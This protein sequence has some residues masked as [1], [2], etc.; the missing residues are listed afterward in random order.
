MRPFRVSVPASSANLGPGFDTLGLA[1]N[2]WN[3]TEFTSGAPRFRLEVQGEGADRLP[4]SQ[5]NLIYT[6]LIHT[7]R[8]ARQ[9]PPAGLHIRCLNRI[10]LGAGLGS[11]AAACLTGI[12]AANQF[13][14]GV[15]DRAQVIALAA[16]LEGHADNAAP[17]ALGGLTV[18]AHGASGLLARRVAAPDLAAVV[19]TPEFHLPTK[20]ARAALPDAYPRTDAIANIGR[21]ALVVEALRT[22]DRALLAEVIGDSL[23]QPYRLPLIPGAA[24]A[25]AAANGLGAPAALSGAGPSLIAFPADEPQNVGAAMQAAFAAAGLA[26]QVRLLHT[27]AEGARITNI[28]KVP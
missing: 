14:N 4:A 28:Q 17:A 22:N 13:L 27:S 19:V 18:V 15:F 10:P 21:T 5:K 8:A 26:S 23:H 7:L 11:S 2:L 24:E 3:E 6:A 1:L 12:L 25:L 20:K 16:E 9:S